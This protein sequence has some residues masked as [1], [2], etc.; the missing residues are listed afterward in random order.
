VALVNPLDNVCGR[1]H[2]KAIEATAN[3]ASLNLFPVLGT[4]FVSAQN[5]LIGSWNSEAEALHALRII[6]TGPPGFSRGEICANSRFPS[7]MT[8]RKAKAKAARS[9]RP[10]VFAL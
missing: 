8:T 7:G 2:R 10:F 5:V 4:V 9:E 1:I 3:L 6:E